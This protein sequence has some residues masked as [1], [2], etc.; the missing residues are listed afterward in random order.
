VL[1]ALVSV[2]IS[3]MEECFGA[4]GEKSSKTHYDLTTDIPTIH[5][6][7]GDHVSCGFTSQIP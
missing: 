3:S 1:T 5:Y 4:A 7:V 6:A 2:F